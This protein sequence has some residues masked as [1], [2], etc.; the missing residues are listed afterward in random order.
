MLCAVEAIRLGKWRTYGEDYELCAPDV[1]DLLPLRVGLLTTYEALICHGDIP[2]V[3]IFLLS[4]TR[5]WMTLISGFI[6]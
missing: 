4:H 5:F 2:L 3:V 1:L 6:S